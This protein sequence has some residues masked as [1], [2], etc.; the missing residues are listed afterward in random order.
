V[1]PRVAA[2]NQP[3][4]LVS[5]REIERG[6][7]YGNILRPISSQGSR[8]RRRCRVP[9]AC[10]GVDGLWVRQFWA[11]RITRGHAPGRISMFFCPHP[12]FK[13]RGWLHRLLSACASPALMPGDGARM[14]RAGHHDDPSQCFRHKDAIGICTR[15]GKRWTRCKPNTGIQGTCRPKKSLEPVSRLT[16][17]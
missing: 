9:Q 16:R 4:D 10:R 5:Q 8:G 13:G 15:V 3:C 7:L 2:D 14:P 17:V 12:I 6:G 11:I 1:R